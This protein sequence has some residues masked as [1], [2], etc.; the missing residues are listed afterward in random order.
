MKIRICKGTI[1]GESE[2]KRNDRSR[3]SNRPSRWKTFTKQKSS[4]DENEDAEQV[5]PIGEVEFR[6]ERESE[7]E[8]AGD[9]QREYIIVEATTANKKLLTIKKEVIKVLQTLIWAPP[10]ERED[11]CERR[12][13]EGGAREK[14]V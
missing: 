13:E 7:H 9:Q 11:R 14:I 6:D 10:R 1:K 3:K 5:E 4:V 12:R 8:D 2:R